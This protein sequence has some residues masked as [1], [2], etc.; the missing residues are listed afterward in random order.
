MS[1]KER[2]MTPFQISAKDEPKTVVLLVPINYG[3]GVWSLYVDYSRKPLSLL[4]VDTVY[5]YWK[6]GKFMRNQ[7][8]INVVPD[9]TVR[10]NMNAA[11][12]YFQF[13][14]G[15]LEKDGVETEPLS[16]VQWKEKTVAEITLIVPA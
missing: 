7:F 8:A 3:N 5:G 2:N 14:I 16:F 10:G 1:E 12:E 6:D 9:E 4:R 15:S 13:V 11:L